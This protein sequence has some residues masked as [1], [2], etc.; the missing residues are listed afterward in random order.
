[1]TSAKWIARVVVR[2]HHAIYR[3]STIWGCR[4]TGPVC[5]AALPRLYAGSTPDTRLRRKYERFVAGGA[6]VRGQGHVA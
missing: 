6:L 2:A 3:H 5:R 1:M 4:I